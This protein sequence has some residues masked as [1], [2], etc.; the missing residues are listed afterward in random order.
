MKLIGEGQN[1][2]VYLHKGKVHRIS[3]LSISNDLSV[4]EVIR[5]VNAQYALKALHTDYINNEIIFQCASYDL[6]TYLYS[7]KKMSEQLAVKIIHSISSML[8]NL[9]KHPH[10]FI[11]GDMK[12]ENI[13]VVMKNKKP[14]FKLN[15]F[16]SSSIYNY[17][18]KQRIGK[19]CINISQSFM[20]RKIKKDNHVVYRLHSP[21]HLA[22][23]RSHFNWFAYHKKPIFLY[24][25]LYIF[26]VSYISHPIIF[27]IWKTSKSKNGALYTLWSSLWIKSELDQ[28]DKEFK[29]HCMENVR[30]YSFKNTDEFVSKFYLKVKPIIGKVN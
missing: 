1:S 5:N 19:S 21:F 24:Y 15:D 8:Q 22:F 14:Q 2:R 11:H 18:S 13:L 27:N 23:I 20:F 16:D 6:S 3:K 9:K 4:R 30:P 17:K 28:V 29:I 12:I 25:D 7:Q 26:I 10:Y